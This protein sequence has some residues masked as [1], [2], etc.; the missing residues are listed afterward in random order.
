M[1]KGYG[2]GYFAM[3]GGRSF[4]A[5][6]CVAWPTAEICAMS[7]EG[8]VDVAY[9]RDYEAA[10]DPAARRQ[11]LIDI[12]KSQLGALRAAEHFG[13]DTV[14]DPRDTRSFLI[15]TFAACPAR[16]QSKHPPKFRSISPI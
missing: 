7:V 8:A 14:I 13:I 11:E 1:R 9:R 5:D 2:A 16:H 6:A 4:D 10:E 12:F 3:A 15:D